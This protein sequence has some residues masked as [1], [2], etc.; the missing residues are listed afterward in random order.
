MLDPDELAEQSI[1]VPAVLADAQI[2]LWQ[3]SA[4]S[5]LHL[6]GDQATCQHGPGPRWGK[7][8]APAPVTERV[9]AMGFELS[10]NSMCI[11]CSR[12]I[13]VSAA[14]DLFVAL[15]AET[16]RAAQWIAEGQQ[17][18][19][20]DWSWR[21]F[22]RWRARQPLRSSSWA[23]KTAGLKGAQWKA[24]SVAL[25]ARIEE[26]GA[27]AATTV[28]QLAAH[29]S[30]DAG[31]T[32]LLERAIVMVYSESAARQESEQIAAFS[33]CPGV[34]AATSLM[35]AQEGSRPES[36]YREMQPLP[37]ALIA[38]MWKS[39]REAGQAADAA[40][41]SGALDGFFPH[42][43]DLQAL[44][45]SA[46]VAPAGCLHTWAVQTARHHRRI[47]VEDWVCRLDLAWDGLRGSNRD[48]SDDCS[49]LLLVEGWP[50]T[51]D[52][53]SSVAYLT[54]FEVVCGPITMYYMQYG[55]RE[56]RIITVLRVPEWAAVHA[57]ERHR[58]MPSE[59]AD[60]SALQAVALARR[61]GAQILSEEFGRRRKPSA[62]VAA[63]RD[64]RAA[65]QWDPYGYG[66]DR[67]DRPLQEGALP[68]RRYGRDEKEWTRFNVRHAMECGTQF[69]Y[70]HD[71]LALMALGFP[72]GDNWAAQVRIE[73]EL[74]TSCPN[75]DGVHLC[76]IDGLLSSVEKNGA[77][78]FTPDGMRDTVQ[79][80]GAYL[81][82]LAFTR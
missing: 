17:A 50:L 48:N 52:A 3:S 73:V 30:G 69:V 29:V 58:Y 35:Y 36:C 23:S 28:K 44:E 81:V 61:G 64:R 55:F 56:D 18:V 79:I 82:G 9:A 53:S 72:A 15:A 51:G 1:P 21:Q 80:P 27:L 19:G 63:A 41:Y 40:G 12:R 25:R 66:T 76:A 68:P 62:Q 38:G 6:S 78:A 74:Q 75:H 39:D 49:H 46:E 47:L 37:W 13:S 11:S 54:Q 31:Q 65:G 70:G 33:M 34:P 16:M 67:Y 71:D 7:R 59:A 32:A 14:A 4:K 45:C 10:E 2:P 42:V 20:D 26:L 22:A 57:S 77:I 5:K 60:G 8:N 24:S 43:H